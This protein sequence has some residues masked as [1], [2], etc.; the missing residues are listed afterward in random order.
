MPLR[1]VASPFCSCAAIGSL[2][3]VWWTMTMGVGVGWFGWRWGGV[4]L[5]AVSFRGATWIISMGVL[6]AVGIMDR[7][8]GILI[9]CD[10]NK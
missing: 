3:V 6:Y 4:I 10:S 2:A 7:L 1:S 5:P 9:L 8:L